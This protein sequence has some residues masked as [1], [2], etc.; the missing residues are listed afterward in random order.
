M[1]VYWLM[2]L[3]PG[4]AAIFSR[5]DVKGRGEAARNDT[6]LVLAMILFF[7]L[8]N[9]LSI[10]RFDTGGDWYT[11]DILV[12]QIRISDYAYA[13]SRGDDAFMT[14]AY[15][16]T[17]LGLDLYGVNFVC[18]ALLS[19]GVLAMARRLPDP[20]VAIAAAVPY[21]LIVIG[22]G[23]I[24]QGAAIGLIL[25]AINAVVDRNYI[26][27]LI[28]MLLAMLFHFGAIVVLPFVGL[29]LVRRNPLAMAGVGLIGMVIFAYVF[30][31]DR[32]YILEIGY[33][34]NAR[35]SGGAGVRLLM[36]LLP[37]LLFLVRRNK[38]NLDPLE[39]GIWS[40]FA[41]FC[42][43]L[44]AA[45][46][47]TPSSTAVDRVALFFSPIQIFVFGYSLQLLGVR[48]RGAPLVIVGLLG[49]SAL[50]FAVWAFF[51]DH[52]QFWIPYRS[53]FDIT[54]I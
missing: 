5:R 3:F 17:R 42:I 27:S 6:V 8:Y 1:L 22:F 18:S 26:R 44:M 47:L 35:E 37:S 36:N 34:D 50:V 43:V 32:L 49:Y 29:A 11:Y 15:A 28:W 19:W 41:W 52:S 45:L 7:I 14:V 20:W 21:I 31:S 16:S 23:Y 53:I 38:L 9:V 33:L 24:R 30:T 46:Y 10:L 25:I 40:N 39:R 13:L 4:A 51:A 48:A 54:P 12:Q 2:L